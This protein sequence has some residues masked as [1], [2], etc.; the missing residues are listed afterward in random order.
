MIRCG[1]LRIM[2][3]KGEREKN[4]DELLG[5]KRV[6]PLLM[7]MAIPTVIS[8]F[9][10]SMYNV[11]DSIFVAQ[12][13]QEALTAVSLAYPMQNLVLAVSVGAGVGIGSRISRSLGEKK[14]DE[15]NVY[16]AHGGLLTLF[17]AFV[18]LMA[19][20]F[21]SAPFL[22][23]YTK[24]ASIFAQ[25]LSYL[26]I[27][28]S[29]AVF[30]LIYIFIEKLLQAVG[31]T[32]FPMIMQG[33]GALVNIVLD[34][35]FI[36]GWGAIPAMGVSGAAIATVIGQ[37][38]SCGLAIVFFIF[39]SGGLRLFPKGFRFSWKKIGAI[40]AVGVPSGLMLAMPSVLVSMMN[41]ILDSISEAAVN[42]YG[43][44]YKLQTFIYVPA[45][46]LVQGMRPIVGYNHG[47]KDFKRVDETVLYSVLFVGAIIL[48]GTVLFEA[49]PGPIL[50]LFDSEGEL[51]KIGVLALRILSS[52]FVVST[53]GV[54]LS[55]AFEALGMGIKSLLVTLTRQ[56][57]L[58]PLL[59][60][61]FMPFWGLTGVWITYPIAETAAAVLA[62]VFYLRYRKKRE[63]VVST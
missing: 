27:V 50:S 63:N 23:L 3:E 8:M 12:W 43:V 29:S 45:S 26:R 54:I 32:L 57:V 15:A 11:V 5:Q 62:V 42:F 17:N 13:S 28:V 34:P 56:F 21:L 6:F 1:I 25:G 48:L 55:G 24:D 7:K 44:F 37:A 14:P 19:G 52:G 16:A 20:L 10:Q 58:I 49:I 51:Q 4:T 2:K 47:A 53:L 59:S 30:S 40:C 46:G 41:A 35:I 39:R 36:F 33:V 22:S 18:F 31:N 9:I 38:V 61:V 60:L